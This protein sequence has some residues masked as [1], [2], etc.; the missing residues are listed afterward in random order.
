LE[1]VATA[2]SPPAA[3]GVLE[4]CSA[5]WLGQHPLPNAHS[6]F[7]KQEASGGEGPGTIISIF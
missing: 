5:W 6:E 2:V 3:S 1:A 4:G 7:I